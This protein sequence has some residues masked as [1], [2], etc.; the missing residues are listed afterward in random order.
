MKILHIRFCNLNSLGGT[1]SIDLTGPEYAANGIFAITGPTG[2]GKSTILDAVCLALYGRTPRLRQ[3]SKSGNEIMTRHTGECWSEVEFS[4]ARGQYR[5]HWSQHRA[6]KSAAGELQPPRHEIVDCAGNRPLETKIKMVSQ[7]VVEVIGM[8]YDQFT[9]SVLLAQGDF[10]TFLKANADER[11]P[12]LE[13][14]TGTEIYS[15]ISRKVHERKTEES[16]KLEQL[17]S[18][19]NGFAPLPA[20]QLAEM[21]GRLAE[22]VKAAEACRT[23]IEDCRRLLDWHAR[24]ERLQQEIDR[25]G[26]RLQELRQQWQALE[27][28]RQLLARAERGRQLEAEYTR[29][30]DLRTLQLQELEELARAASLH[31]QLARELQETMEKEGE[32]GKHLL[33]AK[34]EA[35]EL[36]SILRDVRNLDQRL[37]MLSGQ[38]SELAGELEA[39]SARKKETEKGC[40]SLAREIADIDNSLLE[41]GKYLKEHGEDRS[42][43]EAYSGIEQQLLQ[44]GELAAGQAAVRGQLPGLQE[45]LTR[46]EGGVAAKRN[47]AS[48]LAARVAELEGRRTALDRQLDQLLAGSPPE[49]LFERETA[50]RQRLHLLEQAREQAGRLAKTERELATHAA[51]KSQ[52]Q[53]QLQMLPERCRQLSAEFALRQQTVEQQQRIVRLAAKLRDYEQERRLL[54]EGDPCPLCGSLSHPYRTHDTGPSEDLESVRLQEE[55]ARLEEIR[56]RLTGAQ[57]E[58]AATDREDQL[59]DRTLSETTRERDEIRQALASLA[60]QL[61]LPPDDEPMERLT[62]AQTELGA[63]LNGLQN[64]RREAERL[65]RER[66][67]V[68]RSVDNLGKEVGAAERDLQNFLFQQEK[69]QTLLRQR[70]EELAEL[71]DTLGHKQLGLQERLRPYTDRLLTPASCEQVV[72]NLAKRRNEWLENE[73]QQ[74]VLAARLQQQ[75][76][77]ETSRKALLARQLE[78]CRKLQARLDQLDQVIAEVRQQRHLLFGEGQ[79]DEAER[80]TAA[81]L[82]QCELQLK[83]LGNRLTGLREKHAV[84]ASGKATLEQR[85]RERAGQLRLQ[86]EGFHRALFAAG[87]ADEQDFLAGRLDAERHAELRSMIEQ[88][89]KGIDEAQALLASNT[90]TLLAERSRQL[91]EKPP[92]EIHDLLA[93]EQEQY[94]TLQQETGALQ[95]RQQD[96]ER[97]RRL[98]AEKLE[99]LAARKTELERWSRLHEL[100]GSADGKKFRN[101]AQGLT[102]EIM[103]G[104]ANTSLAQMSDRYLLVRD[105]LEPLELQVIDN[106]QGGAIRSVRNL[107]GGESFIVSMALAL[108]LS[109]MASRN[110]QVDSLFLDEGFGTLDEEALQTALDT[111]AGLHQEGKLIGVISHVSGLRE[112]ISTQIRVVPGLGGRSRLQ[113]PGIS[114]GRP[115]PAT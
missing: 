101:F 55:T 80:T 97:Q 11:A 89:Q 25:Q 10:N 66:Q 13:Q 79:P 111:L 110:V 60:G 77:E 112:R 42:L 30:Q 27:P 41:L 74:Q 86:E 52:V 36:E 16:G 51:R 100:I 99:Q 48:T 103:I 65:Q 45:Q 38:R 5:C 83:E 115:N 91:T 24:Q 14:I 58:L 35:K 104:H 19:C 96:D 57:T 90:E 18:E 63:S 3:V 56:L 33:Q 88:R 102:F 9:R 109:G 67:E 64:L 12:I 98:H 62:R 2:A 4:T 34:R 82:E 69:L 59:L 68:S 43:V 39:E 47:Q 46:L 7:K 1:W 70:T 81:R 113:G 92:Q 108:G 17:K 85:T 6:R 87:F 72:R 61:E 21:S 32:A 22:L 78:T 37:Q 15:R 54:R 31:D 29:F 23:R 93:E 20:E 105:P 84:V 107:S 49:Q 75:R 94:S 44:Y 40:A 26:A 95:Q 114:G 76:A 71:T 50:I 106:Y 53:A 28:Q 8:N 73:R